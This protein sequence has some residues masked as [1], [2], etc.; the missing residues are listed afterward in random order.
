MI[1]GVPREIKSNENRVSITPSG[2]K[3]LSEKGHK[4]LVQKSAG[5]GSSFTDDDFISS[6]ATMFN[7]IEDIYSR[8]DMIVKVKE[9]LSDEYN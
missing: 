3:Y 1:I 8:S 6:G 9:P 5:Q 2:V 4:V 7:L